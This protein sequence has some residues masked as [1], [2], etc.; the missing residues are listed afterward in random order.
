MSRVVVDSSILLAFIREEPHADEFLASDTEAVV[1]AI[2]LA[3]VHSKLISQGA[4]EEQGWQEATSLADEIVPF[5]EEH[6]R[7]TGS[8]I[9]QTKM[10]GLSLGD[11][12]CLALGILLRLPVYTTDRAW[13]N[14]RVG[15]EVHLVR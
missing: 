2:N 12:A 1:S 6:A 10:H 11:R 8:L 7:M 5:F 9:S 14:V 15:V 4:S 3:E 13:K